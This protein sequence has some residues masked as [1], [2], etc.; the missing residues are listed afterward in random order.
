MGRGRRGGE[1]GGWPHLRTSK[2]NEAGEGLVLELE[3]GVEGLSGYRGRGH[4]TILGS[5]HTN[6][7][8]LSS[9][10]RACLAPYL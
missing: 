6:S 10:G 8:D 4:N 1:R 3:R 9:C 7:G 2:R 5:P